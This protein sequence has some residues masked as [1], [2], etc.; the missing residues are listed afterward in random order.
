MSVEPQLHYGGSAAVAAVL[1]ALMSFTTLPVT[2]NLMTNRSHK[3]QVSFR[4]GHGGIH[5]SRNPM[6]DK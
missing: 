2:I 3:S 6:S 5:K 1:E 4:D